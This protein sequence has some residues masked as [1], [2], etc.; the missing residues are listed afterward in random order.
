[1]KKS[2]DFC[3]FSSRFRAKKAGFRRLQPND[4]GRR[5]DAGLVRTRRNFSRAGR[6]FHSLKQYVTRTGVRRRRRRFTS[7]MFHVKQNMNKNPLADWIFTR[8]N[9]FSP[10][11]LRA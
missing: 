5:G 11:A 10:A 2:R 4:C 8:G 7:G 6:A 1:M 3:A 9:R